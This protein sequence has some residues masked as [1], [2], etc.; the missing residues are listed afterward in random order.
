MPANSAVGRPRPIPSLAWYLSPL[1][2][3]NR[4]GSI[5]A[6]ER[7]RAKRGSHETRQRIKWAEKR[8]ARGQKR[9]LVGFSVGSR[10]RPGKRKTS[11]ASE[12]HRTATRTACHAVPSGDY[13]FWFL[14]SSSP[15]AGSEVGVHVAS[16]WSRSHR[17]GHIEDH[18]PTKQLP[19][20]KFS[21]PRLQR[22][23]EYP[24]LDSYATWIFPTCRRPVPPAFIPKACWAPSFPAFL[25]CGRVPVQMDFGVCWGNGGLGTA[26]AAHVSS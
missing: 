18:I 7:E 20:S 3:C 6:R 4:A 26:A 1:P 12:H 17:R 25:G 19:N 8:Q 24:N 5:G 22:E 23:S 21:V 13:W 16:S 2:L 10:E 9:R 15:R 14:G 11:M